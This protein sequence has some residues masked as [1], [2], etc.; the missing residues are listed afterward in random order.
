ML[1]LMFFTIPQFYYLQGALPTPWS[2]QGVSHMNIQYFFV[3]KLL[4]RNHI[5]CSKNVLKLTYSNV[6]FQNFPDEDPGH[7]ASR[8]RD[9]RGWEG[10]G[11]EG[12]WGWPLDSPLRGGRRRVGGMAGRKVLREEGKV[13]G[14]G[15]RKSGRGN[16]DPQCQ[17][18]SPRLWPG[19]CQTAVRL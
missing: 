8:G 2:P 12:R 9:G 3:L 16:P 14:C 15:W 17:I 7:P 18:C 19:I 4:T 6:E 1:M 5:S 10:R 11:G 13:G